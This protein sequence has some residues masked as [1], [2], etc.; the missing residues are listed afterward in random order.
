MW[1]SIDFLV[2]I[3]Q[4]KTPVILQLS[5]PQTIDSSQSQAG[6]LSKDEL[7]YWKKDALEARCFGYIREIIENTNP[8]LI[9]IAGDVT[10]GEFDHNGEHL[11]AFVAFMES[12]QIPWAPVLGNHETES[13]MG[14]DW[15]C[16]LFASAKHCLFKQ[17][18]LTGNG[19]YSVGVKQGDKLLRVFYMLDSNGGRPSQTSIANGHSDAPVGF[20]EDQIAWYTESIRAL[21][22]CSKET[23]VGFVFHIPLA[24]FKKAYAKYGYDGTRESCPIEIANGNGDFGYILHP[25]GVWDLDE[26]VW[27]GLKELGV[28]CICVGHDHEVNASVVYEGVRLQFGLKSST[29]DSNLYLTE[30]GE[31]VKSWTPCGTP[32]IGGTVMELSTDGCIENAYHYYCKKVQFEKND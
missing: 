31:M 2:E 14:A 1:D 19:N 18:T 21:H 9:L 4:G 29:Y 24:V 32:V 17:R 26:T 11:K 13:K 22:D 27:N 16:E 20:G 30:T 25:F 6:R 12:F 8:D 7:S 5:D 10:Y 28:D 15:Q 23:K 3:P